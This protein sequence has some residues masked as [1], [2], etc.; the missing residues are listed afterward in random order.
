MTFAIKNRSIF[1]IILQ[2][3]RVVTEFMFTPQHWDIIN[4]RVQNIGFLMQY[5]KEHGRSPSLPFCRY[6]QW[7]KTKG[8]NPYIFDFHPV[9]ED[10]G[11]ETK[12]ALGSY[13]IQFNETI[14]Y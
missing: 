4:E 10:V 7:L 14:L 12:W 3:R 8:A 2:F 5:Q 13:L 1:D 6:I 11:K 9:T